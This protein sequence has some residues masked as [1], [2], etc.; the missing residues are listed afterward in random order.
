M[1][2]NKAHDTLDHG[3]PGPIIYSFKWKSNDVDRMLMY[4][5]LLKKEYKWLKLK[6][7]ERTV[8]LKVLIR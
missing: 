8:R 3:V 1:S 6:R 2:D 7:K 5:I 4:T